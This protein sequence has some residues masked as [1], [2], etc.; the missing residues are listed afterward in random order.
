[1]HGGDVDSW[2]TPNLPVCVG[3]SAREAQS[4]ARAPQVGASALSVRLPPHQAPAPKRRF[5]VQLQC[6]SSCPVPLAKIF[7]LLFFR[8]CDLITASRPNEGAL[9]DRHGRRVRD[10][11]GVSGRSM[12]SMPT[13]DPDATVKSR[14]SGIPVLMPSRRM[15][16]R[17][18][19]GQDSRS[20]GRARISRNTIARG[21]PGVFGQ[22]CGDCRQLFF[23]LAGHGRGQRPVFPAPSA[24]TRAMFSSPTRVQCAARTRVHGLRNGR[25]R[26]EI[27][28]TACMVV[29]G[30]ACH[31]GVMVAMDLSYHIIRRPRVACSALS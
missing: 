11:V 27:A 19:R 30:G 16:N 26:Y 28:H 24:E 10:A 13:N 31:G 7:W 1:L 9:R 3:L 22:T 2:H 5:V 20:P 17:W 25:D 15:T 6:G 8:N 4:E 12:V 21:R 29:I 23:L 14:G 18:R